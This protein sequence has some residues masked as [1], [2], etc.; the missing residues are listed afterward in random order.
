MMKFYREEASRILAGQKKMSTIL[1]AKCGT[2]RN[3]FHRKTL[4]AKRMT[5]DTNWTSG[6]RS[7]HC[8]KAEEG[9]G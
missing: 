1:M 3:P 7:L 5:V 9:S 4:T 2:A 6:I 8:G